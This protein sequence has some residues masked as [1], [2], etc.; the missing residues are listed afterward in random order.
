MAKNLP[1]GTYLYFY[2]LDPK[3][4]DEDLQS[5]ITARTGVILPLANIDVRAGR[6]SVRAIVAFEP[7]HLCGIITWAFTDD[8][9][10]G[11]TLIAERSRVENAA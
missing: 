11:A 8:R 2:D 6:Y 9:I 10:H 1:R 7:H 3:T 4:T 5:L